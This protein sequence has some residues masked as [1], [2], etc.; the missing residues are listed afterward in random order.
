MRNDDSCH[1]DNFDHPNM[2]TPTPKSALK[3]TPPCITVTLAELAR[4]LHEMGTTEPVSATRL[5]HTLLRLQ[6]APLSAQSES[7]R[8]VYS[9]EQYST[10]FSTATGGPNDQGSPSEIK[11]NSDVL[12]H[13]EIRL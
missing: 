10:N 3:E 4:A 2:S 5:Y 9:N 13:K 1:C 7:N 8:G 11:P 12:S 6:S